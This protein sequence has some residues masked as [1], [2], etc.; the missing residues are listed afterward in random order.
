MQTTRK[1]KKQNSAYHAYKK[2]IQSVPE[3]NVKRF[4]FFFDDSY[5][6]LNNMKD[7]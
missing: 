4:G 3:N 5:K 2:A 7:N 1:L 6:L